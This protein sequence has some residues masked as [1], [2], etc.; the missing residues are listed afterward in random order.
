MKQAEIIA[1]ANQK[2]GVGKTTTAVNLGTSLARQGKKVLLVDLDPQA[3]L[4]MCMGH[5]NPDQLP[6]T[7]SN[8]FM[9]HIEDNFT[10]T[11]SD[12]LI[13]VE[14]C[15]LIPS[16]IQLAGIEPSII[17]AMSRESI[18]KSFLE[19]FKNEYDYIIVDC[20]PSLGML[21]VNAFVASTSVLIPVQAHFL[22]A[23]G[24]EMLTATI[25]KIKRSINPKLEYK[26]ILF[27][28]HNERLKISKTVFEDV[29]S[30][31]GKHIRIFE[32]T[33][34][35]SVKAVEPTFSGLSAHKYA[36][37]SKVAIAYDKFAKEVLIDG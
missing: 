3:N 6:C 1:I 7:I 26:G 25:A 19:Q 17:N 5:Q 23:K 24:L 22:S 11:P 12:Y 37:N 14:G 36:P 18:L 31:Y 8:I 32:Q 20:M 16:S 4:T 29:S 15:D 34:P 28:M 30:A 21:T 10:L 13:S 9:E 2:G 35:Q 27:T 33:I